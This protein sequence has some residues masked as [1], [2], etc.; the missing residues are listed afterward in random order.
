[1]AVP[2]GWGSTPLEADLVR[3]G[4]AASVVWVALGVSSWNGG[5]RVRGGMPALHAV[6]G[7]GGSHKVVGWI[8]IWPGSRTAGSSQASVARSAYCV[9][10]DGVR[11]S[12]C[13]S[14]SVLPHSWGT[15]LGMPGCS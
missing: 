7:S 11:G 14:P 2:S 10:G 1:L 5:R 12:P 15:W 4:R 6:R 3:A 8:L 13:F 9:G